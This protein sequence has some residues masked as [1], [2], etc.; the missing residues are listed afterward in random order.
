MVIN[1]FCMEPLDL[2]PGS[3]VKVAG[4]DAHHD[5]AP[6]HHAHHRAFTGLY[7]IVGALSMVRGREPDARLAAELA[8]LAP[9]DTVVANPGG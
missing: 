1:V 4:M 3:T 5:V 9:T 6:N 7:G 2:N 8:Q